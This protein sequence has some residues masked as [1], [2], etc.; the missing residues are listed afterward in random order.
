MDTPEAHTHA[1]LHEGLVDRRD[2]EIHKRLLRRVQRIPHPPVLLP[3]GACRK[4]S[5]Q[6]K[7]AAGQ[8]QRHAQS[9]GMYCERQATPQVLVTPILAVYG[10]ETYGSDVRALA[11]QR[12]L[13]DVREHLR[14][15]FRLGVALSA[16]CELPGLCHLRTMMQPTQPS[17]RA[18]A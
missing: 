12:H 1:D 4:T 2:L 3:S 8:Q 9:V 10:H 18:L 13:V 6:R 16:K 5:E 15:L 14:R 11:L 17:A 7:G